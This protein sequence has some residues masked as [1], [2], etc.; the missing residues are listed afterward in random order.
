MSNIQKSWKV[1]CEDYP[2]EMQISGSRRAKYFKLGDKLPLKYRDDS[3]FKWNKEGFLLDAGNN[4]VIKNI[5]TAFTPRFMSLNSQ[6]LYS[7]NIHHSVRAKVVGFLHEYFS[8]LMKEQLP[9]KI[10]LAEDERLMMILH[11]HLSFTKQKL[12]SDA[13][14][15]NFFFQKCIQDCLGENRIKGEEKHY[16]LGVIPDDSLRYMIGGGFLFSDSEIKKLEI[17]LF[18]VNKDV[19]LSI[20][21]QYLNSL[22]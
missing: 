7:G 3:I 10:K 9:S 18:I 16:K 17:N 21:D 2:T 8:K 6:A 20:I 5:K 12:N 4:K 14:N 1:V 19:N 22:K 11:H 13:D 15:F